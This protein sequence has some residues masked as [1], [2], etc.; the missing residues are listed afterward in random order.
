M[1][2]SSILTN[3]ELLDRY[4]RNFSETEW[5]ATILFT[6]EQSIEKE[7]LILAVA[8]KYLGE[9]GPSVLRAFRE[10][11][12]PDFMYFPSERIKIGDSN[13]PG[14]IRY[15][16]QKVLAY[17]PRNGKL[18]FIFFS[19]ASFIT[20]E[21]ES[22][23]L[24][25]LEEPPEKTVFLLSANF[26]EE[27][28]PTILS[29]SLQIDIKPLPPLIS[30]WP[31]ERFWQYAGNFPGRI[32]HAI[33]QAQ[34]RDFLKSQYDKLTFSKNDFLIFDQIIGSEAE[35]KF[36]GETLDIQL[37]IARIS[38]LP[39]YFSLRDSLLFGMATMG[40]IQIPLASASLL[41][42]LSHSLENFF[43]LANTRYFNTIPPN[44]N[45]AIS[46]FLAAF[47][48]NWSQLTGTSIP[49]QAEK[50]QAATG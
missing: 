11:S 44:Y 25:S 2:H 1:A 26:T 29:R 23:L 27:L 42:R 50:N 16:L 40:P 45:V 18:R 19:N 41:R 30:Q 47:I 4:F 10:N 13:E 7:N 32:E 38:L 39:L 8:A 17:A 37:Q 9:S 5:P 31:W 35:K 14:T 6:G 49:E 28:K 34:W 21:A 3:E 24:K 15:L 46:S 22:A 36:Q 12:Y 33:N 43:E 48:E 20:D